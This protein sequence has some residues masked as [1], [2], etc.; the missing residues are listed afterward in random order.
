MSVP[1]HRHL[2]LFNR[3]RRI[4]NRSKGLKLIRKV[5]LRLKQGALIKAIVQCTRYY[6]RSSMN[7]RLRQNGC[8]HFRTTSTFPILIRLCLRIQRPLICAAR[9]LFNNSFI[10]P[11]IQRATF[12][13]R[14]TLIITRPST[15]TS[16]HLSTILVRNS[17]GHH[18]RLIHF[19]FLG[20]SNH[21]GTTRSVHLSN[22]HPMLLFRLKRSSRTK[23]YLILIL[24][25]RSFLRL[26][27]RIIFLTSIHRTLCRLMVM[28]SL[29]QITV[30][31]VFLI[32]TPRHIR[33]RRLS[34]IILRVRLRKNNHYYWYYYRGS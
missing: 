30:S 11:M 32:Y 10:F 20:T 16:N 1:H 9:G 8:F 27:V 13:K 15:Q 3:F 31:I 2:L 28:S 5:N 22:R 18:N 25:N 12:K 21:V 29:R 23:L 6:R 19:P 26:M 14:S 17:S 4:L 7:M 33:H 24:N 34:I